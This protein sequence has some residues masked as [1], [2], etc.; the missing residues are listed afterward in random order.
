LNQLNFYAENLKTVEAEQTKANIAF[1]GSMLGRLVPRTT[2][3]IIQVRKNSIRSIETLLQILSICSK[4][5]PEQLED[6]ALS[7]KLLHS[8]GE[9]LNQNDSNL[10]LLSVNELAKV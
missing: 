8:I 10:L 6:E 9:K 1:F 5:D 7:A 2:D 4:Q 3:P